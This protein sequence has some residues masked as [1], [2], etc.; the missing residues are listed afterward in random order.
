MLENPI[1]AMAVFALTG[2]MIIFEPNLASCCEHGHK[3]GA[4]LSVMQL[5]RNSFSGSLEDDLNALKLRGEEEMDGWVERRKVEFES[6]DT[7]D[8]WMETRKGGSE[9]SGIMNGWEERSVGEREARDTFD[10]LMERRE[11]PAEK[12]NKGI[13]ESG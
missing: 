3:D 13:Y 8:K 6:E 11:D 10:E 9:I 5:N 1:S 2:K 12:R 7:M 4:T